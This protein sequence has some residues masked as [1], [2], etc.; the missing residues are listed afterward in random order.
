MNEAKILVIGDRRVGKGAVVERLVKDTFNTK[1]G[2]SPSDEIN[3]KIE[4]IQWEV[5]NRVKLNIWDF[6]GQQYEYSTYQFFLTPRSLYLLVVDAG[7]GDQISNIE[8]WL[9]LIDSFSSA[10]PIMIIINQIDLLKGQL[11]FNLGR[12]ALQKRYNI[13]DF[14]EISC[15]NSA[16]IEQLKAAIAREVEEMKHVHDIWPPEWLAIKQRLR[17]MPDDYIPIEMYLK[18]CNEEKLEDHGDREALLGQLHELGIL[19]RFHGDTLVLNPRWVT[20]GVY[21][22][23]ASLQLV[24][25]RERG[26]FDLK[27]VGKIL[28]GLPDAKSHYPLHTHRRLID[29]M[30][31]FELCFEFTD[32]PGHYL[33]PRQLHDDDDELDIP[34]EDADALKIQ[35]HYETLPYAIISRL[36]VRM[37]QYIP[38]Q[39]YWKN[40]VFLQR[41]GN[42]A[43]IKADQVDRKILISI[44]GKKQTR[45]DF[46]VI[47]SEAFD[48]INSNLGIDIEPMI[49]VVPGFPE[50]P[51]SYKKLRIHEELNKDEIFIPELGKKFPVR[52]LLNELEKLLGGRRF[53]QY[54][55][56]AKHGLWST[57]ILFLMATIFLLAA[58]VVASYFLSKYVS[59]TSAIILS[60]IFVALLLTLGLVA[61][62][63][64]VTSGV[65]SQETFRQLMPTIYERL[66]L[67]R[68]KG[69]PNHE[70]KK[71]GNQKRPKASQPRRPKPE[72]SKTS[73]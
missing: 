6:G 13:K 36:I 41:G 45:G 49:F 30:R 25:K 69:E 15:A 3:D 38:K 62:I 39:Y 70:L 24:E 16:G 14:I 51:V 40:G 42:R 65:I 68:G 46:L 33:I 52:K 61:I 2:T 26:Q 29:V 28:A 37:N 63:V 47:I 44:N 20:Q 60:L 73:V 66:P 55:P 71:I 34:W 11:A 32:R 1:K 12:Q 59:V 9:K 35:Y 4:V 72:K 43:K 21:G 17:G 27:D 22:L 19:T 8:S 48:E 5:D 18:I 56:A 53:Q 58:L 7:K 54:M 10:S 64:L 23:L 31:H 50:V 67:L 57:S